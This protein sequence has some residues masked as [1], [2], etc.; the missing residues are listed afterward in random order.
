[1]NAG[2]TFK[3]NNSENSN[4]KKK[5]STNCT[6]ITSSQ[7]DEDGRTIPNYKPPTAYELAALA[8]PM[9]A[10]GKD[11]DE[12]FA[13]A[14]KVFARAEEELLNFETLDERQAAENL[15]C[16]PDVEAEM[17]NA[18][19]PFHKGLGVMPPSCVDFP[20]DYKVFIHGILP[21][22]NGAEREKYFKTHLLATCSSRSKQ[23]EDLT[24]W[25]HLVVETAKQRD[26]Q[27]KKCMGNDSASLISKSRRGG[28]SYKLKRWRK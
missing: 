27:D 4:A 25:N 8:M 18:A 6:M 5:Q 12:A 9:I 14:R 23:I 11:E 24:E 26:W 21:Q 13:M 3:G 17:A 2:R 15:K 7:H 22:R 16:M 20:I 10:S 28:K 1:M 19:A